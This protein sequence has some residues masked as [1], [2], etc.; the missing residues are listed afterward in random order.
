MNNKR[1]RYAFGLGTIGR[2]MLYS[3]ISMYL[4]F[5]LT[6]VLELSTS[7]LWWIT[8]I[9]V[10]A[11]IF[12]AINDPIMGVIVDNTHSRFGKFKPWIAG[13]AFF[14]GLVTIGM[15]TD[16]GVSE[17]TYIIIFTITYLLWDIT[18]TANDISYWSMLPSLSLDQ[19]EREKIGATARICANIGLFTMVALII[20]VTTALG[21]VFGSLQKGYMALA[22][23]VVLIM[24]IGQS[25]TV[26][27]VKETFVV[28]TKQEQTTLRQMVKIIY[29]NDQLLFTVISMALFT[30]G[31]MTTT[32][33]G[34]YFFKYAYGNENMY[35]V[36]AIILGISQVSALL[37]FPFISKYMTRRKFYLMATIIV[38]VGYIVF[39]FAPTHTMTFIGIAGVL[40]FIGEAFIQLMMLMSLADAV[41]YGHW[42]LG[43]RNDSVTFSMQPFINKMGGALATGVV[44][45][46]V[47]ISGIKDA[48]TAADV[49]S[50]GLWMMKTAML[51]FPLI[52]IVVGY[53]I[54]R[55]K[56][57]IDKEMYD[58]IIKELE[59]RNELV[60]KNV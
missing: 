47:I 1:N 38:V 53:I 6:D 20:P 15:F 4:I 32:S 45:A 35:S 10:V 22:I 2:D 12:D 44:G 3:M 51:I 18:F 19:K 33:F 13:G 24:W 56:Y 11:R 9:L 60:E 25:I 14:T 5:Y 26:F 40:I 55:W 34:I 8:A 48:K 59:E 7:T 58:R 46:T 31:Y 17:R 21:N 49:T 16:F 23:I 50:Q 54:Y 52:C 41:E 39:F 37:V 42:K 28:D 29:Q 30:I 57:K 43:R 36:F 27:G